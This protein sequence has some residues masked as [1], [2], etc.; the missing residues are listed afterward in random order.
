MFHIRFIKETFNEICK[1]LAKYL[2]TLDTLGQCTRESKVLK[3]SVFKTNAERT[4]DKRFKFVRYLKIALGKLLP[5]VLEIFIF[6]NPFL[7][8]P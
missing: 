4:R 3:I 5:S 6:V 8:S 2:L 1:M 7:C